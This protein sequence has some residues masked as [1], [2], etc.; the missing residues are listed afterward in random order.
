MI[1]LKNA[2]VIL[3][4]VLT[5]INYFVIFKWIKLFKG[6]NYI[7]MKIGAFTGKFYPPHIGH[8][9]AV[10]YSLTKCDKVIIVISNNASR[11][12]KIKKDYNFDIID[13]KLIKNWFEE[14]YIDN[15]RVE[16]AIIDENGLKP[17]PD[18]QIE[19]V[20]RFKRKFPEVNVKIADESY[21]EFNEKFFPECQFL[22]LERDIIPIHSTLIRKNVMANIQYI[23][24][25]ARDYF[26]NLYGNRK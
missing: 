6:N 1:S 7:N 19:W 2:F 25:T 26:K 20:E 24:P 14:Y 13:A 21:R 3:K 23:I 22:P 18:N 4:Y 8:L 5:L 11:N 17:Y 12:E 15:D 10:D 16:V 9:S